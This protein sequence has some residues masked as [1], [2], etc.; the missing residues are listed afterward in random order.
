MPNKDIRNL[1]A[2]VRWCRKNRYAKGETEFKEL[3]KNEKR[4]KSLS[5]TQIKKLISA[6][7]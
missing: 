7:K 2:F 5:T 4:V 3:K 1:R 6:S